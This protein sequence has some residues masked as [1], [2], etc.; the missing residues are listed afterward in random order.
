MLECL[1]SVFDLLCQS[2]LL[3]FVISSSLMI[4]NA[5]Y[6]YSQ[7]P[8]VIIPVHISPLN[9]R[10][11]NCLPPLVIANLIGIPVLPTR[12]T[13]YPQK[14]TNLIFLVSNKQFQPSKFWL[15]LKA[16]NLSLFSLTPA[17]HTSKSG[18]SYYPN[19]SRICLLFTS[20]VSGLVEITIISC[21]IITWALSPC[22]RK[23]PP[24]LISSQHSS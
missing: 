15:Q 12:P 18:L 20:S 16:E 7:T 23:V 17:P 13:L 22:F 2:A 6:E 3:Y 19:I 14:K 1:S 24:P 11:F 21:W 8:K 9:S 10:P 4:L 5:V